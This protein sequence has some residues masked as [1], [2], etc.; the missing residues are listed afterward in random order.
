GLVAVVEGARPARA[1]LEQPAQ[2]LPDVEVPP[3]DAHA[4]ALVALDESLVGEAD[5]GAARRRL[6]VEH[7]PGADPLAR[8][9]AEGEVLLQHLPRHALPRHRLGDPDPAAVQVLVAVVPLRARG[10]GVPHHRLRPPGAYVADGVV[11]LLRR[12]GD[13]ELRRV[14]LLRHG[15][16]LTA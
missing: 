15:D 12:P 4:V 14:A 9:L 6:E 3:L 11:H 1:G 13:G 7:D 2:A 10:R 5:P 16:L 8:V